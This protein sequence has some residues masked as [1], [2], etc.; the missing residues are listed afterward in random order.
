MISYIPKEYWVTI[1]KV[2]I[3]APV[4][5]ESAASSHV[6]NPTASCGALGERKTPHK[7]TDKAVFT[8]PVS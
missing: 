5:P 6:K 1:F 3:S 7:I 8:P 4:E 2:R